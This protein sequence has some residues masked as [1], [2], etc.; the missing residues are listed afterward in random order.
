MYRHQRLL[1]AMSPVENLELYDWESML[2]CPVVVHHWQFTGLVFLPNAEPQKSIV[3]YLL[4][5]TTTLFQSTPQLLNP[6]YTL[7]N[8][9]TG[10][11]TQKKIAMLCDL[12]TL[13]LKLLKKIHL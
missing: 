5:R 7:F 9:R 3:E 4:N 1:A 2:K 6:N 8:G 12:C 11:Q 13:R 10:K